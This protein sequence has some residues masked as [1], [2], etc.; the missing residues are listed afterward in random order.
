M[1]TFGEFIS[2]KRKEK[3]ITL[4]AMAEELEISTP[5]MSDVEK[6]RRYSFDLEKL[7]K[8]AKIL[9]MSEE[10]KNEMMDLAGKQREE[11]APDLPEY[12]NSTPAVSVAL[13]KARDLNL[14][15]KEWYEFIEKLENDER[16]D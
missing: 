13:R 12:I 2:L 11:V 6:G 15:E 8:I 16:K 4:K 1:K 9:N 5:Y 10:E 7:E 3:R 14:G